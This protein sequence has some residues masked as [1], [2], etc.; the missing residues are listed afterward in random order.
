[1][2]TDSPVNQGIDTIYK[3]QS[4]DRLSSIAERFYG[5]AQYVVDLATRNNI[6]PQDVLYI[7]R[8]LIIPPLASVSAET[9]LPSSPG[10]S[11]PVKHDAE[12]IETVVTSATR[13]P[14]WKDWKFWAVVGV[15]VGVVWIINRKR[16]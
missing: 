11:E 2:N 12:V 13:I 7:G 15:G 16:G 9:T 10:G 4:G 6:N 5:S 3:V 8:T 1:M 14:F